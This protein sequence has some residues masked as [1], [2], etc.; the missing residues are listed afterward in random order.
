MIIIAKL[1]NMQLIKNQIMFYENNLDKLSPEDLVVLEELK[2]QLVQSKKGKSAK[3][4]GASYERTVSKIFKKLLG[5]E[6]VRTPMS[7]GFAKSS[8]KAEEFRGDIVCLDESI[9]FNLHI[10]CKNQKTWKLKDWL[11]QAKSDCPKD[12]VPCVVMHQIREIDGGKETTKSQDYIVL[13]LEDFLKI[14]DKKKIIT[15]K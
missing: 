8:E 10:E 13:E 9:N 15:K 7:G 6:L 4:K 11:F 3:V 5:I 1:T 14:V 2:A 12:K